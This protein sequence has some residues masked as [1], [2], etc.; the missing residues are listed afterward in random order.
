[1]TVPGFG[2]LVSIAIADAL[3][4]RRA[5]GAESIAQPTT[6]LLK[7]MQHERTIDCA[8]SRAVLCDI[9]N[10]QLVGMCPRKFAFHQITRLRR[11]VAC[12]VGAPLA[13]NSL[14]VSARH[15]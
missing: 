1:M 15:H 6:F 12:C 7:D 10:P 11:F 14:K 9:G 13:W 4:T 2:D 5:L 3:V 8:F